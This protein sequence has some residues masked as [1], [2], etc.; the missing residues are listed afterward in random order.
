MSNSCL[1]ASCLLMFAACGD[2]V[3]TP[4]PGGAQLPVVE[5]DF[6]IVPHGQSAVHDFVL[7]PHALGEDL[8]P[9]GV[10]V[11]CRCARYEMLL[12]SADG[13]EREANGQPLPQFAAGPDEKLVVRMRLET[14]D[15]EAVDV[16]KTQS[17][18][19]LVLQPAGA[20]NPEERVFVQIVFQ[21]GID[22]PVRLTPTAHVDF[23]NVPVCEQPV[24]STLLQSDLSERPI[25]F[26]P[27]QVDDPRVQARLE[28]VAD[29]TLLHLTLNPEEAMG[30]FRTLVKIATDLEGDYLLAVPV[31]GR[32]IA[33]LV[34]E[35][36]NKISLGMF[37]FATTQENF[38]NV[39]D[40]DRTRSPEF[41]VVRLLDHEGRDASRYFEVRLEPI[42][43]D[44]RSTRVFAKYLGGAPPPSFRGELLLAKDLE[45]GPFLPIDIVAFHRK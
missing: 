38:V 12:R 14:A 31:S 4:T 40:H 39:T 28:P 37:D 20:T 41:Q 16:P 32:V 19:I 17:R 26:G 1:A 27:A 29:G 7:D 36:I 21:Y 10:R 23:G 33:T 35:P 44:P 18:G 43:G 24:A 2:P 22:A 15:K 25:R 6:G 5:H 3:E 8:I 42:D 9:L 30:P 45:Q 11:D 34:A 13:R